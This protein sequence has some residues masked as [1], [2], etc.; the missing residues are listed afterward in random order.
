MVQSYYT[1][2]IIQQ[3]IQQNGLLDNN[4]CL[5]YVEN[6]RPFSDVD[7]VTYIARI[8]RS[9]INDD[10]LWYELQLMTDSTGDRIPTIDPVLMTSDKIVSDRTIRDIQPR[11]IYNFATFVSSQEQYL[12][13]YIETKDI[14]Y[15]LVASSFVIKDINNINNPLEATSR[16]ALGS[17]IFGL[18]VY[19]E[20]ELPRLMTNPDQAIYVINCPD[21]YIIQ[22]KEHGE[23]ITV[24]SLNT[25]RYLDRIIQALRFDNDLTIKDAL[26]LIRMNSIENLTTLWNIVLY[27]TE[28]YITQSAL[29]QILANYVVKYLTD[30]SLIDTVNDNAIQELP[31][32]NIMLS[33]GY[34]GLL[35]DDVYNNGWDRGC[36]SYDYSQ[37]KIGSQILLQGDNARY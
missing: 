9:F 23:S 35:A 32:N 29:E 3:D 21:S 12:D 34:H 31:I 11:K 24:A 8:I 37:F 17:G 4:E 36:I 6:I 30:D 7:G 20:S 26:A 15:Q 22:D 25:N 19:N 18:Y 2:S 28:D 14:Q 13:N 5:V 16:S 10:I 1:K 33:L 27:R